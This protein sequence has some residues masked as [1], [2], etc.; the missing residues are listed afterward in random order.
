MA[1]KRTKKKR[2]LRIYKDNKNKLFI[3]LDGEKYFL[4]DN[5]GDSVFQGASETDVAQALARIFTREG[6]L[7]GIKRAKKTKKENKAK[8]NKDKLN[9]TSVGDFKQKYG[10][11]GYRSGRA[12]YRRLPNQYERNITTRTYDEIITKLR[13]QMKQEKKAAEDR[14]KQ[15][16]K[17]VDDIEARRKKETADYENQK[18]TLTSKVN[19]L[20]EKIE[21][22]KGKVKEI[23]K[24]IRRDTKKER[25]DDLKAMKEKNEKILEN[26]NKKLEDLSDKEN[27]INLL[28]EEE[29]ISFRKQLDEETNKFREE[30][31]ETIKKLTE[32]WNSIVLAQ[33]DANLNRLLERGQPDPDGVFPVPIKLKFK[34]QDYTIKTVQEAEKFIKMGTELFEG[35][36]KDLKKIEQELT[37]RDEELE[38]KIAIIEQS[39]YEKQKAIAKQ[40]V[41]FEDDVAK[42]AV[43]GLISN[44]RARENESVYKRDDLFNIAKNLNLLS[45][46]ELNNPKNKKLATKA[47]LIGRISEFLGSN[48]G[49][50]VVRD[51]ISTGASSSD[52]I[53]FLSGLPK[54]STETPDIDPEISEFIKEDLP[55]PLTEVSIEETPLAEEKSEPMVY[56]PEVIDQPPI[57]EE[58]G[59]LLGKG[60]K[61]DED[62]GQTDEELLTAAKELELDNFLGVFMAD[63]FDKIIKLIDATEED[64]PFSFIMNTDTRKNNSPETGHWVA[65]LIDPDDE[66]EINY[67]DPLGEPPSKEFLKGLKKIVAK[68]NPAVYLKLKVNGIQHQ[69]DD[70]DNCG[71]FSLKFL[72]DRAAGMP[73]ADSSG[74]S[75]YETTKRGESSIEDFKKEFG[76]I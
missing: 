73:F 49:F 67:F 53:K 52:V 5:S 30:R 45:N 57:S 63:E 31:D 76:F 70:S 8:K 41:E 36:E 15:Y 22:S 18:N 44:L 51:L 66:E 72:V 59:E 60:K 58:P 29:K 20:L 13:D 68:V 19:A 43:S 38:K 48:Q 50:D 26:L 75:E 28:S 40:R 34:S 74:F 16:L 14:E 69:S 61:S 7:T 37:K 32:L 6:G 4:V 39:T 24:E 42:Q 9:L 64:M 21:E 47:D 55:K 25:V 56:I 11:T 35:K 1:G 3:R 23:T 54:L 71:W 12:P 33:S 46:N 10:R 27:K 17:V 62:I 65:V 2:P